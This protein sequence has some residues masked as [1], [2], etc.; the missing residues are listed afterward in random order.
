MSKK[1]IVPTGIM[2]EYGEFLDDPSVLFDEAGA[3]G[4]PLYVPGYSDM[5]RAAD[6]ARAKKEKPKDLPVELRWVRRTKVSG[7]PTNDRLVS[8]KHRHFEAVQF[9]QIGKVDWLT[10][11]PP[12][13]SQLPDGT[14]GNADSV[15]M[16]RTGKAAARRA[17]AKTLKWLEVTTGARD[18]ALQKAAGEV[19][20]GANPVSTTE[21]GPVS[22]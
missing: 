16:V 7:L 15:L 22:K 13:A 12:A 9:D 18:A 3:S 6:L 19:K 14:I 17:V 10:E 4:D 5:R 2:T 8:S 11:C 1:P 21:L 20:Q